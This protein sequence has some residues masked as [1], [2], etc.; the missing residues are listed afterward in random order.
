[1]ITKKHVFISLFAFLFF[2]FVKIKGQT[3]YDELRNQYDENINKNDESALKYVYRYIQKAKQEKNYAELKQGYEDYSYYSANKSEKLKYAD[4]AIAAAKKA[5]ESSLLS[6]A[7]LYKGSLYYFYYKDYSSALNEYLKAFEHSKNDNDE[8][9][10]YKIV[11]QIGLVKSYL[12]YYD[13]ALKHFK[14]CIAYFE[15]KTKEKNHPNQIYNDSKGYLNSLHQSIV[16]RQKKNEYKKADSLTNI[17]LNFTH[18]SKDF[19]LEKAYFIKSK[20][21]SDY[22]H[23]HYESAIKYLNSSLPVLEK[24]DDAYWISVSEFYVGKSLLNTNKEDEAIQQ[25][26]KVDSIFQKR[27]FI[28]PELSENYKQ[29]ISYF[30]K[31]GNN[32]QELHYTKELAKVEGILKKDFPLLSSKIHN[33][34][35]IQI[36]TDIKDRLENTSKWRMGAILVLCL[37]GV[38]LLFSLWKRSQ[39]EKLIKQ[40]YL[41]LEKN[42]QERDTEP[43]SISYENISAEG[44]SVF[45][46]DIFLDLQ[47]KMQDFEKNEEFK[48]QELTLFRLSEK[49]NTNTSY[50]SRYINDAKGM[51]FNKYLSTLRINYITEKLYDNP[52]LMKLKIQGLAIECGFGS[53]QNFSDAFQ[54]ING[55]RPIE[56]IK[57]LKNKKEKSEPVFN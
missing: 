30:Q 4:S 42:I 51:N 34:Y 54:E 28:F 33:G 16:C 38:F 57:L 25:F 50:L 39:N 44:K 11:Y 17:G 36:L 32:E 21:I 46:E 12:G 20:G 5:D 6:S 14:E 56:F 26:K 29:L 35:D 24:N 53:R 15:P 23:G 19:P 43:V 55:I 40:K 22:H 27:T 49:L 48:E 45:N 1:M 18:A 52:D 2:Q 8:Y 9:L 3:S 47:K 10:K 41:D 37:I 31:T 7:Y 13:E